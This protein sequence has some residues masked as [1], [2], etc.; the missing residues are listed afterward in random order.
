MKKVYII[1]L[2]LIFFEF[3]NLFSE[4]WE[5]FPLN[6]TSYYKITKT[7]LPYTTNFES[8]DLI[9]AITIIKFDSVSNQNSN[10]KKYF[11]QIL[12]VN[13]SCIISKKDSLWNDDFPN[14]QP[15]AYLFLGDTLVFLIKE[16]HNIS[17]TCLKLPLNLDQSDSYFQINYD[18]N[19]NSTMKI[20]TKLISKTEKSVFGIIDSVITF[21]IQRNRLPTK[22]DGVFLIELSKKFGLIKFFPLDILAYGGLFDQIQQLELVSVDENKEHYGEVYNFKY[23]NRNLFEKPGNIKIYENIWGEPW[24]LVFIRDSIISVDNSDDRVYV[25][26]NRQ[27]MSTNQ[28][29]KPDINQNY[30][31]FYFKKDSLIHYGFNAMV[32]ALRR[33]ETFIPSTNLFDKIPNEKPTQTPLEIIATPLLFKFIE[34]CGQKDLQIFYIYQAGLD[35]GNCTLPMKFFW[36]RILDYKMDLWWECNNENIFPSL[37]DHYVGIKDGDCEWGDLSWPPKGLSVFE[38]QQYNS[39]LSPNPARSITR[40]NLQ[41]EG[42]I[43]ITAVDLLGRSYPLWSGYASSGDMELDVSTLPTGSYTLLIDYGTK[44]EAVRMMK[45]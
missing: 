19:Y 16:E 18:S 31:Y 22:D 29:I 17:N 28:G 11:S 25:E 27:T 2:T 1:L 21:E 24:D 37:G 42:D 33:G 14:L 13:D 32:D 38:G 7:K 43:S 3:N 4:N 30:K 20:E 40:L 41:Q 36:Y 5:P 6:Q 45:E 44:R 9:D 8:K 12:K 39:Y 34:K 10:N 23:R 35:R 26:Y 15:E